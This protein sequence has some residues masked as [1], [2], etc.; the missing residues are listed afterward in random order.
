MPERRVVATDRAPRPVTAYSQ[1]VA[2][3]GVLHCSGQVPISLADGQLA[4]LPLGEATRLCLQHLTAVCEAAGG[5]LA[6]ALKLTIY[7][8]ALERYAELNDAYAAFFDAEPPAR[9]TIGVAALPLGAEV[10]IEAVVPLP[11]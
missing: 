8:T 7:T 4:Q 6:K 11:S 1:A 9:V 10:E 2:W 5:E 3:N